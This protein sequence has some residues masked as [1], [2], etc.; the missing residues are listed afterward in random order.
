MSR[1]REAPGFFVPADR[2]AFA[3]AGETLAESGGKD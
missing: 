2:A 1:A 3:A